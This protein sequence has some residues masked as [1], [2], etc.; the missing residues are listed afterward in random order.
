MT[1]NST[2]KAETFASGATAILSGISPD[3][4]LFVP[5]TFPQLD[6]AW[7][8]QENLSYHEIVSK[9]L[10]L[11]FPELGNIPCQAVYQSFGED[12]APVTLGK[13]GLYTLELYHGPTCAFKDMALQIL[14]E[15]LS[16]SVTFGHMK[17]K[18]LVLVATSGDT[19]KAALE[20][21][22]DRDGTFVIVFYPRDGVSNMQRQ[23]MVSQ[24]GKN[25]GVTSITGNFDDAQT[26][27]KTLF[28]NPD[29]IEAVSQRGY[30]LTS[31]NSIN[32]GRLVPQIAYAIHAWRSVAKR[33]PNCGVN[34]CV[35][36]GNF[37][38][39]LAVLYAKK[40]GLNIPRLICA[41]NSNRILTDVMTTGEY[42][43]NRDFHVT[44]SPS[45]D[46]LVSSNFERAIHLLSG[47]DTE[48]VRVLME[49]LKKTGRFSLGASL[50][51]EFQKFFSAFSSSEEETLAE[52][53]NSFEQF[54]E[55]WD[56]HTAVARHGARLYAQTGDK[57]PLVVVSTASPFKFPVSMLQ[58]LGE[59]LTSDP[60]AKL[61]AVTKR[62]IPEPL[63]RAMKLPV[64][65]PGESEIAQMGQFV[66]DTIDSPCSM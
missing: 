40:M 46:I 7:L 60:V 52:I 35:P 66:L 20:G 50:L 62:P 29:F 16:R 28:T 56:P 48:L 38:N 65:F 54:G 1:Y 11:Y 63:V 51:K 43:T 59:E 44:H 2:R 39:I 6:P 57:T 4:G 49:T 64:R 31:A 14:P 5:E 27:V 10:S 18:S 8:T 36:T 23:Q 13:D 21:F 32:I 45:M 12:P 9:V 15:L 55:L 53:R 37:G 47:G 41:S 22:A 30:R 25:V 34:F 42:S 58:A 19:G 61:A 26:G 3:G 24:L 17:E 33:N